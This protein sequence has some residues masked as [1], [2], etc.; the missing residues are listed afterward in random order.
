MP[1]FNRITSAIFDAILAPF[2]HGFAW[3]DLLLWPVLAGVVALLIYKAV[4]N[5][6]GI[7][8][9][10]R[11]IVVHLL[12]VVLYREDVLGV[13]GSTARGLGQNLRYLGYNV[14]PML[15]M[16]VP[17][18]IILVQ[19]VAHYAYAP[20]ARGDVQLLAVTL[21]PGAS[22]TARDVSA[23]FPPGVAVQAGPVRTADGRV[24]WRLE[25]VEDGDHAI[26]LRAGDEV[27]EK[28][29]AV[30]DGPRKVP[31][32]RTRG[33]EALLYPGEAAL[34]AGSEF[35]SIELRTPS[36]DLS[37]L[38]SGEGGI[39]LWFFAASLIAGFLLRKR[40]GVTL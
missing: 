8:A 32:L 30:G 36:R 18:T 35:E 33:W 7:A 24:F 34:P 14:V 40:L 23:D 1:T 17:M 26:V 2:G 37:P 20:L 11:R 25:M 19:L 39:L 10:K 15:V 27:Q 22:A 21:A 3:F 28:V 6:A 5:Q 38:P 12:E 9:A 4:S 13:V 29:V 16:I 31:V